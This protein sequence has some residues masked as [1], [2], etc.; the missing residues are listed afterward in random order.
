MK[1]LLHKNHKWAPLSKYEFWKVEDFF[2][3]LKSLWS[4]GPAGD[5]NWALLVT[6]LI[7]KRPG[8]RAAHGSLHNI[9]WPAVRVIIL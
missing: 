1:I 8:E 6:V 4:T 9:F 5:V 2:R 7:E 3:K